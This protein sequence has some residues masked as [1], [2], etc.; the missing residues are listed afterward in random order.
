M[1]QQ[2]EETEQKKESD[3]GDAAM[4]HGA[5]D[6]DTGESEDI[7]IADH[8]AGS[9]SGFEQQV[10]E[11]F[12]T[13]DLAVVA[14]SSG[15][16]TTPNGRNK[17][18]LGVIVFAVL[19]VAGWYLGR[20]MLR[21]SPDAEVAATESVDSGADP[22]DVLGGRSTQDLL[23]Q[24]DELSAPEV[25][26]VVPEESDLPALVEEAEELMEN[27]KFG[28]AVLAWNRVLEIDP[29]N[30]LALRQLETA[31]RGYR[32]EQRRLEDL[33]KAEMLFEEGVYNSSLKILYRLPDDIRPER[34]KQY[35]VNGWYNLGVIAL[36]AGRIDLSLGHFNEI[37]AIA[38][39]DQRGMELRDFAIAYKTRE[40][41]RAFYN[42]VNDLQFREL[43]SG[44]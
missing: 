7:S 26:V 10:E 24:A 32:D 34:V 43:D 8:A 36:K 18:A 23:N 44:L 2:E 41:D 37:Q 38:P 19:L 11:D 27:K 40:K 39:E 35:K 42:R 31:G 3:P 20:D 5:V 30:S 9:G 16:D 29:A 12:N 17:L 13:P 14:D 22:S 28:N 6:L 15:Q 33:R 25:A 4:S 21:E 1:E